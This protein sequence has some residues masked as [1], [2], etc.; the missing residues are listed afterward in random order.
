MQKEKRSFFQMMFGN[1]QGKNKTYGTTVL[2]LTNGS[3]IIG[4]FGDNL[5]R[6]KIFRE[7]LNTLCQNGAKLRIRHEYTP[8]PTSRVTNDL[9]Y[10]LT[11][12]PNFYMNA[13]DFL[14][15]IL[16]SYYENNNAFI[17]IDT[18]GKGN[19]LA[20]YPLDY[21]QVQLLEYQNKIYVQFRF[22]D[23]ETYIVSYDKIIHLR[24]HYN[25]ND[26]YGD[27]NDVLLDT[28]E[29]I[30]VVNDGINSAVKTSANVRGIYEATGILSEE[31]LEK[32]R[33]KFQDAYLNPKTSGG[34]IM[35]DAK[36][37]YVSIDS[38]PVIIDNETMKSI[39]EEVYD[40]FNISEKMVKSTYDEN[41]WNA[42]YE[43]VL[44][45][46]MIQAS[47]E[48]TN[49]CFTRQEISFGNKIVLEANRLAY[50]SW[51]TKINIVSTLMSLGLMETN[52]GREIL[53]MTPFQEGGDK[54]LI[55]LNYVDAKNQNNYQGGNDDGKEN[56]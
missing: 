35:T 26:I 40:Y 48:F 27:S 41:E 50:A 43:S 15:K 36:G 17:Y 14:Y 33:N 30:K 7:T 20:F 38:K 39:K 42:Y 11:Q 31:D 4:N 13:Y 9:N 37:K 49:K 55:S 2:K 47:L 19:I 16:S 5:Y 46:F 28:M 10:L 45:P 29:R 1:S 6:S 24:R 44:E 54:R 52:E 51:D 8:N 12:K 18:D 3:S 32:I 23:G 25:K 22:Y 34:I 21:S 56:E 53:N